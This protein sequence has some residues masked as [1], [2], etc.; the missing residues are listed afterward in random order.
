MGADVGKFGAFFS[1][2]LA[3][4]GCIVTTAYPEWL[5]NSK[6]ASENYL[7]SSYVFH[8]IWWRCNS[9][10]IG[11]FQCDS[12]DQSILGISRKFSFYHS[13]YE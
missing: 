13:I 9:I 11:T 12:Y 2:G 7:M 8:G 3:F 10:Q 6:Q 1:G 4:F 5:R